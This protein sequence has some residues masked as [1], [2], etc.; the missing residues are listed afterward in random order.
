MVVAD[1]IELLKKLDPNYK[2]DAGCEDVDGR[3]VY[4]E[5]PT[6]SVFDDIKEATIY[7]DRE[8]G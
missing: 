7:F 8:D 6:I 4:A 3:Y 5:I 2:I 1:L